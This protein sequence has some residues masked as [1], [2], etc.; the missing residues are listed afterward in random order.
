MYYKIKPETYF[1]AL[2]MFGINLL[3]KCFKCFTA[4]FTFNREFKSFGVLSELILFLIRIYKSVS[5][6]I[7]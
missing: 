5:D 3:L 2:F 6:L 4:K 7:L 1:T